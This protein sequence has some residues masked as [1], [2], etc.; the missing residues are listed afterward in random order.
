VQDGG[1]FFAVARHRL[2]RFVGGPDVVPP[3]IP[4][5]TGTGHKPSPPRP[6]PALAFAFIILG[7][8]MFASAVIVRRRR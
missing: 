3:V 6:W 7:G 5:E 1:G 8:S 2:F 4:P